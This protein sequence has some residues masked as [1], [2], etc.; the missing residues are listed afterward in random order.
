MA[1]QMTYTDVYEDTY[2]ESYWRLMDCNI[3]KPAKTGNVTF[4][5]YA[6]AAQKGKRVIGSKSYVVDASL[7]DQFFGPTVLDPEGANPYESAY[8]MAKAV[9]DELAADGKYKSFFDGAI[10]V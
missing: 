8:L 6:D 7:F 10:D 4:Y 2:P 9:K 5:G 3:N 1:L